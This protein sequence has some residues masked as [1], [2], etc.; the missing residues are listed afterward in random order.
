MKFLDLTEQY[1]EIQPEIEK[2]VLSVLQSGQYVLGPEVEGLEREVA[3][4][5]GARW[6]VGVASGTDALILSLRAL[7]V[8]HGDEVITTPFTFVATAEAI[9]SVGATPVFVDIDP[10]TF[11]ISPSLIAAAIGPGTKAII[12]VHLFGLPARVDEICSVARDN[13]LFVV[14]DC[15][16]AAGAT[17]G[18]KRVGSFGDAAALSFFPT[19]NLGC[20]GDGGM[21]LTGSEDVRES[22]RMLRAHGAREKYQSEVSGYNSRLDA[23]QAAILRVKL[24]HLDRWNEKRRQVASWYDDNLPAGCLPAVPEGVAHVYHLYTIRCTSRDTVEDA[25][26]KEGIPY[27]VYYP[28]PSHLQEAFRDLGVEEGSLPESERASRE[29]LSLPFYPEMSR[30]DALLVASVVRDALQ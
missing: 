18:G 28:V 2:T 21:I 22:V 7:G 25:L 4:Y 14:E 30:D 20:Y 1:R 8:G 19:K 9:R 11:N 24:P 13:G 29:V 16:Q 23:L 3:G 17:A 27:G 26:R 15:A 10:D 5:F 6:A 12:P